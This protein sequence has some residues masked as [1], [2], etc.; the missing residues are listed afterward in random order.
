MAHLAALH[1][2]GHVLAAGPLL[3]PGSELRGLS[4]LNLGVDEALRLKN[5]DPAIQAGLYT[6]VAL[7]WM[8]PAEAMSF[9][10]ARFPRSIAEASG[11]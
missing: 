9:S 5:S 8:V 7:P 4:I 11:G 3:A 2:A 10:P 1:E 6:I